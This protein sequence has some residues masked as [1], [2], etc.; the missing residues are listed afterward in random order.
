M[1]FHWWQDD[2]CVS[3]DEEE[4]KEKKVEADVNE[5]ASD[6]A[7]MGKFKWEAA[8]IGVLKRADDKEIT[9]KKLRK[10][11]FLIVTATSG[12]QLLCRGCAFATS[13]MQLVLL[14]C[15]CYFMDVT[16]PSLMQLVLQGCN[17]YYW[18]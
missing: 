12:M 13:G 17:C 8:I 4:E 7:P 11:V 15:T 9:V 18:V 10:K 6:E 5:E 14:G 1:N 16:G 2:C 3:T